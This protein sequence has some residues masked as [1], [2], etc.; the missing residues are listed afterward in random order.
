MNN[1][2]FY[3]NGSVMARTEDGTVVQYTPDPGETLVIYPTT[4]G[5]EIRL[6]EGS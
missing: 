2:G 3:T 6:Y 4:Y 5:I 1:R